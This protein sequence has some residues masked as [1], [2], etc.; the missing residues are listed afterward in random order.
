M[1]I[2]KI[3]LI[4]IIGLVLAAVATVATLMFVD[5]SVFRNQIE[6]RASEAFG[7]K[8]KIAGPIDLERSL[9]PRIIVEDIS[10]ANPDWATSPYFATAEKVAVQV[11]LIPLFFGKLEVLDVV[12][13]GANLII[14]KGPDG[15][16]NYTFGDRDQSDAPRLFPAVERFQ[17]NDSVIDYKTAD[18]HSMRFGINHARLWN[19]PGE[20]ERIEAKGSTKDMTFTL[21]LAADGA[22]ELSTPENPWSI[23]LDIQGP[24]M[25]LAL[26]GQMEQAFKWQRGDYHI[27]ISGSQADSLETLFGETFPTTGPFDLSANVN[28]YPGSFR[29][30]DITAR[31]QGPAE[32][33]ALNILSGEASG[34]QDDP[35]QVSVQ[36][37]FG[38]TPFALKI[39]SSQSLKG[40]SHTAPWPIAAQ[41]D[42]VDTK[43]TIK[44][45]LIPTNIKERLEFD[46][47]LQGKNLEALAKFLDAGLPQT[48]PYQLSFRT[49]FQEDHFTFSKLKGTI[50]KV[51]PW[52]TL[53]VAQGSITANKKG[54]L[55]ASLDAK[56]D[57]VPLTLSMTGGPTATAKTA[58]K[59]WPLKFEAAA[60]GATIKGEGAIGTSEGGNVLQLATRISGNRFESLSPLFGTS[61]PAIGKFDLR[62]DINSDGT[63]HQINNLQ[64]QARKNRI[65][66]SARWEDKAPRPALSGKLSAKRLT[67]SAFNA[68]SK[69]AAKSK[70][71]GLLDR[72]IKFE[73]LKA[74]DA[75]L[76]LSVKDI[77]D[78]PIPVTDVKSTVTLE[79]GNLGVTF[80]TK[81]AGHPVK[82][83]MQL[84]RRNNV[85]TVSL[86]AKAAKMD[87]GQTL[88]QLKMPD[89]V[90]GTAETVTFDGSSRGNTLR[91]LLAQPSFSVQIKPANLTYTLDVG[92]RIYDFEI[93]SAAIGADKDLPLKGDI[94]G[95]L[96]DVPFNAEFSTA[97]LTQIR[98]AGSPLPLR[99]K[100][101][102]E[103]LQLQAEGSINRPFENK[104]F[105][106][107]YEM[108]GTDIQV[109]DPLANFL[110]P[111]RGEFDTRGRFTANGNR[112]TYEEDLRVGKSDLK[113]NLTIVQQTPRPIV[114]G[115]ITATQIHMDDLQL[116]DVDSETPAAENK[117]RVIPDYTIPVDAFF[118]V[119][120]DIELN[121]KQVRGKLGGLGEIISKFHLRNGQLTSSYSATGSKGAQFNG[122]F[123]VDAASDPPLSRLHIK[124]N[125]IDLGFLLSN[126]EVTDLVEGNVDLLVDLAGS[127]TTRYNILGNVAGRISV[128][129]GPG[130]ISG[131][132]IDLWAADL[133][134]TML[135]NQ[136]E[137][138]DV[139]ETNCLVARIEVGEG[140][141]AIEEFLLDTQRITIAAGGI[142]NLENE[143]L[144]I[145]MA[146]RPKRASLVSLAN[147]VRIQ[148]T[149]TEPEVSVTRLPRRRQVAGSGILAGLVNPAFL[150]FAFSDRGTGEANPCDAAVEHARNRLETE[151]Q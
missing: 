10:I 69:T 11:A 29:V 107:A 27:K 135:S 7:R 44:G 82:G 74:F 106:L 31:L 26:A 116:L 121:A 125:D 83:Q 85:A 87:V 140:Q 114:K 55:T 9:Q 19:I 2:N 130:R 38:E 120:V 94:K 118:A 146:P 93:E 137:S 103:D 59:T 89:I 25:S 56:L 78:S 17:V 51:G 111:L 14:E 66:G 28:K 84:R 128:I 60:S 43:L 136:W 105:E 72:L 12:F 15:V 143:E 104:V 47:R 76:D 22:A 112:F 119:D 150:V 113:A 54:S 73:S 34:G 108:S 133:V 65:T 86:K 57:K 40:I 20:P 48:G 142:L 39:N 88:K 8:F 32:T 90:A 50:E 49:Q 101:H 95:T 35:L 42:V 68:S 138:E 80:R 64:I 144:D 145:I 41:L 124:A 18:G 61:L 1:R 30:T 96:Q 141:A 58:N 110:V 46:A 36:G 131:R 100:F 151:Q 91:A 13:N 63:G 92:D 129:G 5:P 24:D 132:K 6:T 75:K 16:N 21:L 109:I 98:K 67:L 4:V 33:P 99:V 79:N 23:H 70:S 115:L 97:N 102:R 147:P 122:E 62:A 3:V 148:G 52:Q 126:L 81:A 127:G 45:E 123:D 77:V 53:S 134:P 37:Q 139:T 117:S 149:L 71:K